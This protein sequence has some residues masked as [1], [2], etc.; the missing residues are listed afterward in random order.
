MVADNEPPERETSQDPL[1]G[2]DGTDSEE[3]ASHGGEHPMMLA[4]ELCMELKAASEPMPVRHTGSMCQG[5]TWVPCL[6][7]TES[8]L[9]ANGGKCRW[10]TWAPC[11]V[12]LHESHM[13]V[14]TWGPVAV[15]L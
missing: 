8:G 14:H 6:Y 15:W 12:T 2:V 4:H 11:A 1:A 7:G 9:R 3:A 5:I 13:L 10:L